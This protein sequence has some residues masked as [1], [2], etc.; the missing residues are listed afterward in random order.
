MAGGLSAKN[1]QV[2]T[3]AATTLESV[4][5]SVADEAGEI[6]DTSFEDGGYGSLTTGVRQATVN[7]KG[8]WNATANQHTT[9]LNIYAGSTLTT[10]KLYLNSTTGKYWDFP[11]LVILSVNEVAAVRDGIRFDFTAKSK[12]SYTAP[13]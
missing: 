6:D 9:P 2:R 8:F 13:A 1:A 11:T 7:I 3:G 5:W 10:N 4:E 12:G